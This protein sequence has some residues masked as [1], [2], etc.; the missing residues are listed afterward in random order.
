MIGTLTPLARARVDEAISASLLRLR[1]RAARHG[2]RAE[3][4]VA[5]ATRASAGGKRFRPALVVAAYE[6]FGGNSDDNADLWNVVAAVEALHTAFV[7]HDDL[8]DR[9]FER[10][11]V[12]NVGGQYR[13]R[14][15]TAGLSVEASV[16]VA[17]TASVLAG[18]LLLFEATRLI[19]TVAGPAREPLLT[20]FEDAVLRSAAGEMADVEHASGAVVPDARALLDTA[21]DKTAEY[22]FRLPLVAGALLAG[23]DAPFTLLDQLSADL[24]LA[25]Q[26]VDDLIGAF[27]TFDQ[28]G[29]EAGADLR[30]AKLTPLIAFA[31]ESDRW[32]H[33]DDALARVHT[34]PIAVHAA[35]AELTAS[36]ARDRLTGLIGELLQRARVRSADASVDASV[37]ALFTDIIDAIER[38]VP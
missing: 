35:Q 17:D 31:R 33:V 18:D 26:L 1:Q 23:G 6:A 2:E 24:G 8:I 16:Q 14:G 37:R 22:S 27:G 36:G 4:L 20:L 29:R 5:A 13:D 15:L 21:H 30:E 19:A 28:A 32:P 3:A 38:R 25:F 10:R 34:G 7:I 9:D 11:G 12:T